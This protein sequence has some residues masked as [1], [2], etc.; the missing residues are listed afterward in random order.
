MDLRALRLWHWR[1]YLRYEKEAITQRRKVTD[2]TYRTDMNVALSM[3]IEKQ[4]RD[5]ASL[6]IRAVQALNDVVSGAADED[7]K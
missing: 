1:E 4:N 7:D 6:H 3:T 2:G 5:N